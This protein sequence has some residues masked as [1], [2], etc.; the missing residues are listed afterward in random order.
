MKKVIFNC[1]KRF[2]DI[3]D[4]YLKMDMHI[5]SR[6]TDGKNSIGEIVKQAEMLN[7]NK[8]AFTD[9]IRFNSNYF[10]SY[11]DEIKQA[12][13][14]TAMKLF[15]GFETRI[16]NFKGELDVSAEV[17]NTADLSIASVHRFPFSKKL[18]SVEEFSIETAQAIE[19]ELSLNAIEKG[20]FDVIGHSGGMCLS[21]FGLFP[22]QYFETII[23]L[24][25]K[26]DIAFEIN[27][28]YHANIYSEIFILLKKY[29]PLV[30]FGSDAHDIIDIAL[31]VNNAIYR[32]I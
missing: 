14:K 17:Q 1:L 11:F 28:K 30:T 9:H 12:Q 15:T 19:F 29:N 2:N 13:K 21:K 6:W 16:K 23:E 32:S 24:C 22:I 4:E 27:Y 31:W 26:K 7:L 8:I 5:H 3:N 10:F 18:F 20:G 25:S